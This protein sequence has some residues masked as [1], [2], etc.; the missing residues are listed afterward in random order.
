MCLARH[1]THRFPSISD[2]FGAATDSSQPARTR[3]AVRC[4]TQMRLLFRG[5]SADTSECI[6]YIPLAYRLYALKYMGAYS[7]VNEYIY[8][9][10]G[11]FVGLR[12][13]Q[14]RVSA[15][16][17]FVR[18]MHTLG[19]LGGLTADRSECT[20]S[21]CFCFIGYIPYCTWLHTLRYR[22]YFPYPWFL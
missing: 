10:A 15:Y 18:F 14:M 1:H 16:P 19:Y 8:R 5:L 3:S 17:W 4:P 13:V 20:V 21:I 9:A 22:E 11:S 12:R 2:V 7:V 6:Q